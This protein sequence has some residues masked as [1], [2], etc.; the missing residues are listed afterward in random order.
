MRV[1]KQDIIFNA[2]EIKKIEKKYV[3]KRKLCGIKKT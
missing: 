3:R 2:A 1:S